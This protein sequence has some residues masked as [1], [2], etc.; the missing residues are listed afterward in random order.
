MH[1]RSLD[2]FRETFPRRLP[3]AAEFAGRRCLFLDIS[4]PGAGGPD[5]RLG[6][7]QFS[8]LEDQ[9]ARADG[10]GGALMFL[11]AYPADLAD[12]GERTRLLAALARH[13]V[14]AV[15][16]GHTHYNELANDGRT[17]FAAAR[18][19]GQV[20][21]GP[22]GFALMALDASGAVSFRF[23][24]LGERG[25]LAQI[26]AP[27]DRRLVTQ[28]AP[29]PPPG[30]PFELRALALPAGRVEACR[31]RLDEGEWLA[32]QRVD[33]RLWTASVRAPD[34]PFRVV[35]EA[36]ADGASDC[37][38]IDIAPHGHHTSPARV[39]AGSDEDRIGAWAEKHIHGGQ[40]GPNRNG[41]KW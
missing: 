16:M 1:P 21:E 8:W 24:P 31:Y 19:I 29:P 5:F 2:A 11:H 41:R 10:Q 39:G 35:V 27:A 37:D 22:P 32:M 38:A 7:A 26:V 3:A 25:P 4:G 17:I 30:E 9:L 18:S 14:F 28:Q 13:R 20:E 33:A 6:P 23:R 34:A 36:R 40:L 12:A 15:G